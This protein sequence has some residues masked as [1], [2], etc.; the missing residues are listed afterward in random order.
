MVETVLGEPAFW[1]FWGAL[2]YAGTALTRA[3]WGEL[4]ATGAPRKLALA[5]FGIAIIFGPVAAEG[6][7]PTL[8]HWFPALDPKALALTIGLSANYIWPLAVKALGK[9]VVTRIEKGTL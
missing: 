4:P 8:F 2:V 6:F 3:L 7:G 9:R 5:E 1:G